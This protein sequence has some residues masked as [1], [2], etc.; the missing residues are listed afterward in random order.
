MDSS[1]QY[2]QISGGGARAG[3]GDGGFISQDGGQLDRENNMDQN[4]R[5]AASHVPPLGESQNVALSGQVDLTSSTN[6]MVTLPFETSLRESDGTEEG[7]RNHNRRGVDLL[8]DDG[9][10][11]QEEGG[12]GGRDVGDSIWN[13]LDSSLLTDSPAS[14]ST[15]INLLNENAPP[16]FDQTQDI[17]RQDGREEPTS[18]NSEERAHSMSDH[19][20]THDRPVGEFSSENRN[21]LSTEFF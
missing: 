15:N 13:H 18:R 4:K 11:S 7:G 20:T 9:N 21:N 17:S 1:A 12:G 19:S 3:S 2:S 16:S 5:S 6:P 10:I 8:I 14:Q